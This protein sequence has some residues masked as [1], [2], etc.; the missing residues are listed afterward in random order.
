MSGAVV[1]L[2]I[3][4]PT[5]A[6]WWLTAQALCRHETE[7]LKRQLDEEEEHY[8]KEKNMERNYQQDADD[9][10]A[11]LDALRAEAEPHSQC[12][13]A[14][15][16]WCLASCS[17][18]HRDVQSWA[19]QCCLAIMTGLLWVRH[20]VCTVCRAF[21]PNVQSLSWPSCLLDRA[22]SR[23]LSRMKPVRSIM[24][25]RLLSSVLICFD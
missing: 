7:T 11:R 22:A 3:C 6:D 9:A 1:M 18:G 13:P 12:A 25:R 16:A 8:R 17:A 4:R 21:I 2:K 24:P 23:W 20:R 14:S 10:K 19:S 15:V 5:S